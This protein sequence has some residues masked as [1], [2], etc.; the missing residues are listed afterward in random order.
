MK[1]VVLALMACLIPLGMLGTPVSAQGG[2]AF[3]DGEW[4]G[5]I[6]YIASHEFY[7]LTQTDAGFNGTFDLTAL[8]G[9]LDG[10]F[11][12]D[13][14]GIQESVFTDG[15]W[16]T[17]TS[18]GIIFGGAEAPVMSIETMELEV[19]TDAGGQILT[20]NRVLTP[21]DVGPMELPV[22][23]TFASCER[24]EGDA[25]RS[26]QEAVES[27][28][29]SA[30]VP[31]QTWLALRTGS[32]P[33][34]ATAF[35][36][37]VAMLTEDA[38]FLLADA[39]AGDPI[40]ASEWQELVDRGAQLLAAIGRAD[41][42]GGVARPLHRNIVARWVTD[43]L[44]LVLEDPG[45]FGLNTV[46]QVLSLAYESGAIGSGA[47]T[48]EADELEADAIEN[49]EMRLEAAIA[50]GDTT[51]LIV[52]AALAEQMG[53]RSIADRANEALGSLS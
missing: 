44:V 12:Y 18:T 8:G 51:E 47:G 45:S 39:R 40:D 52:I 41:E 31:E 5:I 10:T 25:S 35:E 20:Q 9:E 46:A 28:G 33:D 3:A 32:V 4:S 21:A 13:G 38:Y 36:D 34:A 27:A 11:Q 37:Q 29:G 19:H 42:C 50:A 6:S 43:L 30:R 49:I 16:F 26:Y 23:I 14:G 7:S 53:W 48:A 15:G 24:V 1:R 17:S 22:R 2:L